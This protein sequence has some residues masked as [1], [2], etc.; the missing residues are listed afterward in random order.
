M[1]QSAISPSGSRRAPRADFELALDQALSTL[2]Q[3]LG[4][5]R[6]LEALARAKQQI[7][8]AAAA[9]VAAE[10]RRVVQ[11]LTPAR[12]RKEVREL[13]DVYEAVL[14]YVDDLERQPVI[15]GE[16]RRLWCRGEIRW[17]L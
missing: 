16:V 1:A 6:R 4:P 12:L 10:R 2:D 14:D 13:L 17:M 15:A 11:A 9:M 8:A 3:P 5:R 7:L